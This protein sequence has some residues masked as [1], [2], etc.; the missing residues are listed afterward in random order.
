MSFVVISGTGVFTPPESISNEELV[1]AFNLYVDHFN[2]DHAAAIADGSLEPLQRS[3]CEF[4]EKASGIKKRHVMNRSGIL[5]PLLMRPDIPERSNDSLSLQA[6]MGVEAARQAMAAAGKGADEIDAVLVAC[7]NLQRPYPAIAIEIQDALGID[8][9]AVDMN[10]ACSSAVF[11]IQAARDAILQGSA[12]AVLVI[13]PEICTGHLN[14][15]DRDSHFIFGDACSAILLEDASL[16]RVTTPFEVVSTRLKTSFTNAIRNNFGFM[17]RA[18]PAA[19]D[20][21]DKLFVQQGRKVFKEVTQMVSDL[22]GEHLAANGI[23]PSGVR[24][25]WLH[26]A[27]MNMNTLIGR[28]VMGRELTADDAPVILDTYA[29]TSSAGS[30]IAFHTCQDDVQ[31]GEVGV[32]CAFGAGYSVGSAILRRVQL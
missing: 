31:P 4:I 30:I 28:K 14:F 24:R 21:P 9:Y 27:N 26:Q 19:R 22:I 3:S 16:C 23:E 10:M 29:N 13:S 5:D 1:T 17:N 11:A 18:C 8:G 12:R 25:L 6:E 32:L 15:T 7:S 2:A 20:N